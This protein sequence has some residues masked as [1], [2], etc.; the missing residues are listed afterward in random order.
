[1]ECDVPLIFAR[2]ECFGV[3]LRNYGRPFRPGFLMV[4]PN[5]IVCIRSGNESRVH[6]TAVQYRVAPLTAS[7]FCGEQILVVL[8][9]T[10]KDSSSSETRHIAT[11]GWRPGPL[12]SP[13]GLLLQ[14][15]FGTSPDVPS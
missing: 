6:S 2:S 9:G 4:C 1:M 12:W 13:T 5:C 11:L 7:C 3:G 14:T 15:L 10:K 8:Q